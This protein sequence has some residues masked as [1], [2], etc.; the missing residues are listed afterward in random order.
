MEDLTRLGLVL[1][2]VP[3]VVFAAG[4]ALGLSGR[5]LTRHRR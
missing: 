5:W 1:I 3:V 4:V 2:S